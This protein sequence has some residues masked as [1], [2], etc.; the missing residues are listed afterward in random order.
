M[1]RSHSDRDFSEYN[2]A[3]AERAVRPLA[4][5]AVAL[6]HSDAA[7]ELPGGNEPTSGNDPTAGRDRPVAV[8][9]G[10]G[11]GI[12]ARFLAENG[13]T[14]HVYDVDPSVSGA[15]E[16]L[17]AELPVHAEIL[18]LSQLRELPGADLILACASLPF[19]P[20]GSFDT[21]WDVM[22][23]GLRARGILAVDLFGE[24]DDWAGTDGT[25]LTRP[26][27]EAL[28]DG[29]EVLELVEEERDGRSFSGPKHWH[30]YR[31]LARRP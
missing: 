1:Q 19:L 29:L 22:R 13:F 17:A 16:E 15:L 24:R 12:E 30:T 3:Q 23:A 21:L 10:C 20:R 26:E 28:L 11:R 8:E 14:V 5:R 2:A 9:L 18:D 25:F 6:A 27:V 4:Q 7:E 31:V